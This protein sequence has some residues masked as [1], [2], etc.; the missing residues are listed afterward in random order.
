MSFL[1]P[2]LENGWEVDQAI[3][4]EEDKV[5]CIRFGRDSEPLCMQQDEILVKCAEAV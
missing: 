4:S 3:L 2:H 1:L 5:I